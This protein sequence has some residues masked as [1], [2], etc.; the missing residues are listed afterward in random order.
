[1]EFM[2]ENLSIEM[3]CP[4]PGPVSRMYGKYKRLKAKAGELEE[5]DPVTKERKMMRRAEISAH[6]ANFCEK[7]KA[8]KAISRLQAAEDQEFENVE[9]EANFLHEY[10]IFD[11]K[12]DRGFYYDKLADPGPYVRFF[13]QDY[14]SVCLLLTCMYTLLP[15]RTLWGKNGSGSLEDRELCN[16]HG[17]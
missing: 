4:H 5:D 12:L 17:M 2:T 3:P 10:E 13:F 7:R 1:M 11:K 15:P 14:L 16:L 9:D 6:W 8:I